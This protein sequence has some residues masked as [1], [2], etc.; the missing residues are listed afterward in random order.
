MPT[1][2]AIPSAQDFEACLDNMPQP[3]LKNHCNI[4][5]WADAVAVV[6]IKAQNPLEN[7]PTVTLTVKCLQVYS[8][9]TSAQL[10]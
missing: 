7:N 10:M 6:T 8:T 1:A 9:Q 4:P 3:Q 2:P 5:R